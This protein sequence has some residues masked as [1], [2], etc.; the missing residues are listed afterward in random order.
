MASLMDAVAILYRV[1]AHLDAASDDAAL[2]IVR[3][4]WIELGNESGM[5]SLKFLE[6]SAKAKQLA[7]LPMAG[8]WKSAR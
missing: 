8:F 4:T 6:L 7:G 1:A 3:D 2:Q 5:G